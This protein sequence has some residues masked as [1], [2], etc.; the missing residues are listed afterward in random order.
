MYTA[1]PVPFPVKPY[2]EGS[3][4]FIRAKSTENFVQKLVW[5]YQAKVE[6]HTFLWTRACSVLIN[7][8]F[9]IVIFY[10]YIFNIWCKLNNCQK[11]KVA[12]VHLVGNGDD[13]DYFKTLSHSSGVAFE[14]H[15]FLAQEEVFTIYKEAHVFL[16]PTTASEGFPK[17]IGL[18]AF[19]ERLQLA[20]KRLQL[21]REPTAR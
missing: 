12:T 11:Q 10:I 9:S 6:N 3:Q 16:M 1:V 2:R 15:G 13:F 19:I 21:A 17:V 14:F 5:L 20:L 4:I 18:R 8:L 7:I